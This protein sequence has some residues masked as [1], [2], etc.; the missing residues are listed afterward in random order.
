MRPG[1]MRSCAWTSSRRS[2]SCPLLRRQRK[3][4]SRRRWPPQPRGKRRKRRRHHHLNRHVSVRRH[5]GSRY[6]PLPLG[7]LP[8]NS[9]LATSGTFRAAYRLCCRTA[10]VRLYQKSEG[11][12]FTSSSPC[13]RETPP[14]RHIDPER[15]PGMPFRARQDHESEETT[16][17][18]TGNTRARFQVLPPP[19]PR[20]CVRDARRGAAA[21]QAL[22][23]AAFAA[24]KLDAFAHELYGEIAHAGEIAAWP[25][26]EQ[27]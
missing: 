15:S 18:S 20:L 7:A 3:I 6:A 1:S 10:P 17:R 22:Q 23:C 12:V 11:D 2:K 14:A 21:G 4:A 25:N 5:P 9:Y 24:A 16:G 27:A 26:S 19:P 8:G 13:P